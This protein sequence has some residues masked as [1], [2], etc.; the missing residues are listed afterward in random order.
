TRR[1]RPGR[2]RPAPHLVRDH[3]EDLLGEPRPH[4]GDA[5]G[6]RRRHAVPIRHL[7]VL[8]VA[9][10][11]G[12]ALAR[13]LPARAVVA[14]PRRDHHRDRAGPG[15]LLRGGLPPA[16]PREEPRWVLRPRGDGREL[17]GRDRR[18]RRPLTVKENT[19][20]IEV[21]YQAFVSDGGEEFGAVRAVTPDFV[22]VWVENAGEFR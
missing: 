1:G 17:P 16:V 12:G 5:A 3:A 13:C 20:D 14:S 4:A 9:A 22:L 21:G 15:V 8:G 2:V 10:R 11:G 6:Q 18:G 7:L 19:M